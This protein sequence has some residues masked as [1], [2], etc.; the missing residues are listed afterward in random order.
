MSERMDIAYTECEACEGRGGEL[1]HDTQGDGVW[2]TPVSYFIPCDDCLHNGLC[3]GCS[4]AIPAD[5][6]T[7]AL[8]DT[9]KWTCGACGWHVDYDRLTPEIDWGY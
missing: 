9:D 2:A 5:E 1:E 3:P 6:A 8:D 7:A 4:R